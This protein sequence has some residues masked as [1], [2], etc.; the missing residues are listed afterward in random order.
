MLIQH[1]E[2]FAISHGPPTTLYR[3]DSMFFK[4][5]VDIEKEILLGPQHSGQR[6]PHNQNLVL[7]R[8]SRTNGFIEGIRFTQAGLQGRVE[9]LER[10]ANGIRV[11][12]G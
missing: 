12:I 3:I 6:L 2:P 4:P 11:Q 7:A 1:V 10:I 9:P 5:F 8:A